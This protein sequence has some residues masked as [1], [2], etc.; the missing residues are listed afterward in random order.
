M[1]TIMLRVSAEKKLVD[2]HSNYPVN[3][4]PETFRRQGEGFETYKILIKDKF[5]N[6]QDCDGDKFQLF[7]CFHSSGKLSYDEVF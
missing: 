6:L 2:T 3:I 4:N 5:G 1:L 7:R